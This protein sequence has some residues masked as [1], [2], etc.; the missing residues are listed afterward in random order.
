MMSRPHPALGWLY[1]SPNEWGLIFR[2]LLEERD[3]IADPSFSGQPPAFL[4]WVELEMPGLAAR[5]PVQF[6]QRIAD[7]QHLLNNRM[8]DIKRGRLDLKPEAD[9]IQEEIVSLQKLL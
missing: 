5:Y 8:D 6:K 7:L 2:R 1:V 3:R 4:A 9:R